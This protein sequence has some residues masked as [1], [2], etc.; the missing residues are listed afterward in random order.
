MTALYER[1]RPKTWSEIVGQDKIVKVLRRLAVAGGRAYWISGASG[2]GKTSIA[3][4]IAAGVADQWATYTFD[5][6]TQLT[7][8]RL[9]GLWVQRRYRP[10]GR[11]YCNIVNECHGLRTD[12]IRKLLGLIEGLPDWVT[13]VFTTTLAGQQRMFDCEDTN[14][15]LSRCITVTLNSDVALPF[16]KRAKE[17]AQAENLDG[18]P[19]TDYIRLVNEHRGNMR[20]VLQAI[21]AGGML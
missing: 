5:D 4:L 6:P 14:P 15:L 13:W 11:G 19:L 2:T 17:I 9:E 1:Y 8:E 20:G 10:L 3:C 12:Q 18:R 16:A 7:A 21:E